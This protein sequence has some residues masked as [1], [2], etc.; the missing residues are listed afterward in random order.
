MISRFL[1]LDSEVVCAP[2]FDPRQL[3]RKIAVNRFRRTD[4]SSLL[5]SAPEVAPVENE[6]LKLQDLTERLKKLERENHRLKRIGLVAL[7][8]AGLLV[9][10]GQA[11]S[12]RVVEA[13]TFVLKD[14]S[15]QVRAELKTDEDSSPRLVLFDAHGG[16]RAWLDLSKK[17]EPALRFWD[18]SGKPLLELSTAVDRPRL[19]LF[20]PQGNDGLTVWTAKEGG[21]GLV[22]YGPEGLRVG[23]TDKQGKP[24]AIAFESNGEPKTIREWNLEG[25]TLELVDPQR[26]SARFGV[27][28]FMSESTGETSKTSAASIILLD[29]DKRV[30]WR[31][32]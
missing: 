25:P 27:S 23:L 29:K 10:A 12:N 11:K 6:I 21:S 31:A 30:I 13:N 4:G 8:L 7:A 32:P 19:T 2:F 1:S 9:L 24:F 18:A 3:V 22:M 5:Q 28:G 15:G 14:I 17:G 20:S 16:G 26:W